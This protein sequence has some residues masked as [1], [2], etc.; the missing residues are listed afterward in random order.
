MAPLGPHA[1]FKLKEAEEFGV[2]SRDVDTAINSPDIVLADTKTGN[3]VAVNYAAKIAVPYSVKGGER[4]VKTII[5]SSEIE[6]MVEKR[7]RSGRWNRL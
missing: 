3:I 7:R 2:T 5:Y 4:T 6:E 1:K